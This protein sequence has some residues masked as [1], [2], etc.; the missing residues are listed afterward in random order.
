MNNVAVFQNVK[1]AMIILILNFTSCVD[2][3][4]KF[5]GKEYDNQLIKDYFKFYIK[6]MFFFLGMHF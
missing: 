3:L 1:N 6:K 2:L 4:F 5:E